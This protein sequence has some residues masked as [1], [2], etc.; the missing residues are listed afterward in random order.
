MHIFPS[1]TSLGK[2]S[3]NQELGFDTAFFSSSSP[4]F[5]NVLNTLMRHAHSDAPYQAALPERGIAQVSPAQPDP[6]SVHANPPASV[7]Q[8]E[9]PVN[10]E[11]FARLREKLEKLGVDKDVLV[12]VEDLFEQATPVTWRQVFE[13]LREPLE[14]KAGIKLSAAQQHDLLHLFNKF[15]FTP[16]DAK[17][18]IQDL[19]DNKYDAVWKKVEQMLSSLTSGEKI[20]KASINPQEIS[21]LLQALGL[22]KDTAGSSKT[23]TSSSDQAA[24]AKLQGL[25]EQDLQKLD[26]KIQAAL[27]KVVDTLS[28]GE[29][30][31]DPETMAA[32]KTV[33]NSAAK[34]EIQLDS[35]TL[36][37]IKRLSA[38]NGKI[39][40]KLEHITQQLT[41]KELS[42]EELRNLLAML[43]DAA[44]ANDQSGKAARGEILSEIHK[45]MAQAEIKKQ[46]LTQADRMET[47]PTTSR[48]SQVDVLGAMKT[49]TEGDGK[50]SGLTDQNAGR[51]NRH[52]GDN[53]NKSAQGW[54]NFW[55]KINVKGSA[56]GPATIIRDAGIDTRSALGQTSSANAAEAAAR[57]II[58]NAPAP[59]QAVLRQVHS[60][61]LQNLGQG[62]QQLTLQ[63][64]PPDL[65]SLTVNLK[66]VGK[67]IQAVLR[68]ENQEARQIISENMPL[69]RHA[70]E[71][72]GLRVSRLEVQPQLQDQNQ[73]SH[74]WQGTDSKKFQEQGARTQW[75]ALGRGQFKDSASGQDSPERLA[76]LQAMGREGGIDLIA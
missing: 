34:G 65:G 37:A 32:L 30:K 5:S 9:L 29:L 40:N 11:D 73:F 54:D 42:P 3:N 2:S 38:D 67:E 26:P 13:V 24:L 19:M 52:A 62:R 1:F 10:R 64:N 58:S 22:N 76:V 71:A 46:H 16:Q 57:K 55:N 6:L 21:S 7:H 48:L 31:L 51:N 74:L 49:A 53:G 36:A 15:G 45:G 35:D 27:K 28:K 14:N 66:I 41:N 70:L 68:A 23:K 60:G 61:L 4:D 44:A 63:L 59:H 12:R 39:G 50:G 18:L 25:N 17:V 43:K 8:K 72:Q 20:A 75:S 56:D 69:L 47:G 33:L